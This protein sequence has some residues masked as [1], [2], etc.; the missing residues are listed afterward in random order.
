LAGGSIDLDAV[1]VAASEGGTY[2]LPAGSSM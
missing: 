2:V 1:R